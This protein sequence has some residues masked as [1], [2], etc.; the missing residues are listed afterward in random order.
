MNLKR[1]YIAVINC[2]TICDCNVGYT[3]FTVHVLVYPNKVENGVIVRLLMIFYSKSEC[4]D[5]N[6]IHHSNKRLLKYEIVLVLETGFATPHTEWL[7]TVILW[8]PFLTDLCDFT[9]LSTF[10]ILILFCTVSKISMYS[11]LYILTKLL[12]SSMFKWSHSCKNFKIIIHK[13][14][15]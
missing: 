10:F 3:E 13:N 7:N 12:L 11:L 1:K 14:E 4:I 5:R 15:F 8:L 6:N 2:H 9:H